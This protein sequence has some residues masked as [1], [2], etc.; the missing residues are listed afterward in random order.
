[1]L[2]AMSSVEKLQKA[3]EITINAGYQL[4][5]DAFEFL[6]KLASME[7][8]V[9]VMNKAL[10]KIDTL[11]I[12]PLF[13]EREFL[14]EIIKKAETIEETI[15]QTKSLE[16]PQTSPKPQL[17]GQD[18]QQVQLLEGK[19][20]FRPYA[21]EVEAKINIIE[22]P[23]D[24]LSSAGTLGDYLEYFRDRFKRVEK[25]LRQRIDA[26]SAA[27]I[28]EALKAPAGAKLKIIGMI[29]EKRES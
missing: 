15:G 3:V 12:K 23:G 27:S 14:E 22:N 18:T 1:M 6:S 20:L 28:I 13:I 16:L 11:E 25:L 24:K 29:T 5:K 17:Q 8:P 10:E 2:K 7:D 19:K 9:G 21:K 26:Q 4:N